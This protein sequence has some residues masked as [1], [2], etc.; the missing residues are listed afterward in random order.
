MQETG[1]KKEK[2]KRLKD[3]KKLKAE[4][5]RLKEKDGSRGRWRVSR[6]LPILL[7]VT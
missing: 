6:G 1:E 4:S 2:G 3:K 7:I 5:S